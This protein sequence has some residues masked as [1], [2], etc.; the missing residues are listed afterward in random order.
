[1]RASVSFYNYGQTNIPASAIN[2]V[3]IAVGASHCLAIKANGTVVGW[4][5]NFVGEINIPASANN[6]IAAVAAG[7]EHSLA[8]RI[9]G[10]VIAWGN[11]SYGLRNIPAEATNVV[12]IGAGLNHNLAV[13]AD[14]SVF[15]W[16][17]NDVGQ[18]NVPSDVSRLNL[19]FTVR[20]SVNPD[21]SDIY[22]L[23]Y[24]ATNAAGAVATT[25]RTVVVTDT[26]PPILTLVGASPL[27]L[28]VGTPFTDPGATAF[29]ACE[30]DLTASIVSTGTVNTAAPGSYTLNYTVTD[31]N[32]NPA[33]TN[34]TVLVRDAPAILG[35][36]AFFS[37]TNAVT[38][39]PVVQ[40]LA[41]VNPNGL[42]TVAFAQ[43]GLNTSYPGRTAS[44]NLPASYNTSTFFA[45][46]DGLIPGAT[47]H[48]RV[49]A[50]NSLGVAY[51]PGQT[52]TGPT[53][54][55][56]GDLNGDG[57]VDQTELDNVLSNFWL[58]SPSLVM[59]NPS[60]LGGGLFQFALTNVTGWNLSVFASTN[61]TDWELLPVPARPV[62]QFLDPA[63]TNYPQRFYRLQWP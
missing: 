37:G 2:V 45:T 24:S 30:G 55:A 52:F 3:A 5:N 13:R 36:N 17:D 14:G 16:G 44:V 22:V 41:D 57:R 34:R 28:D 49:A 39:S 33:T 25:T 51:G 48:F 62:W 46:L 23:N 12:A 26:T 9:D 15:A 29:D 32:G 40:F 6:V 11:S 10:V 38:G 18:I 7:D 1:V 53:L 42:A 59:T 43:Y 27:N 35:F 21:A 54:F 50:S 8:L 47:Y 60:T 63:Y 56:A 58:T 61:L 20:G 19:P 4:G 31:S